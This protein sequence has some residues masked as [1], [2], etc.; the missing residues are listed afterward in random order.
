MSLALCHPPPLP[1]L[2]TISTVDHL[3][4][5]SPP[6]THTLAVRW[7][8]HQNG[9]QIF[10]RNYEHKIW[11]NDNA[12][13]TIISFLGYKEL[14]SFTLINVLTV[15]LVKLEEEQLWSRLTK[16]VFGCNLISLAHAPNTSKKLFQLLVQKRKNL[17][18]HAARTAGMK[19][20]SQRSRI[21]LQQL[22]QTFPQ[23]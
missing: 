1:T 22:F 12:L 19:T 7:V 5:S 4:S 13:S 15:N 11:W 10:R 17:Y 16:Y 3:F 6:G 9:T 20:F 14:V 23:F 18:Q 21:P 2:P 8:R